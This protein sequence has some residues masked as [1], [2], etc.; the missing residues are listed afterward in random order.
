MVPD[1]A[2]EVLSAAQHLIGLKMSLARRAA[3]MQIFQF[4]PTTGRNNGGRVGLFALHIQCPWRLEGPG[5]IVTGYEDLSEPVSPDDALKED[6]DYEKDSN[7]RD[8]R[9][10]EL[11]GGLDEATR[12][13]QNDTNLLTVEHVDADEVGGLMLGLSGGYRLVLFP[14][15]SRSEGWRLFVPGSDDPHFVVAGG[16]VE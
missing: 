11:F 1:T 12:T 6:W 9:L 14:T 7:L 15:S 3:D 10:E 5:G 8:R 13:I 2:R 4:G 16:R